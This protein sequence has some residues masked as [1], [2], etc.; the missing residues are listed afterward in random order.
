[1]V[2]AIRKYDPEHHLSISFH[3]SLFHPILFLLSGIPWLYPHVLP[4]PFELKSQ[5]K[6]YMSSGKATIKQTAD[7]K[8]KGT[9]SQADSENCFGMYLNAVDLHKML[10]CTKT[11]TPKL[12]QTF[13]SP[14]WVKLR[15]K[16]RYSIEIPCAQNSSWAQETVIAVSWPCTPK[17]NQ[18]PGRWDPD[19]PE[20]RRW[21]LSGAAGRQ[22][23]KRD[24]HMGT[25]MSKGLTP[26]GKLLGAEHSWKSGAQSGHWALANPTPIPAENLSPHRQC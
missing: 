10:K 8:N 5:E 1:M 7:F 23:F 18:S 19:F 17:W 20:S 13:R 4:L 24:P 16:L 15:D 3:L 14:S 12:K 2:Q 6:K 9:Y 22:L 21:M 26:N 11:Q 25:N